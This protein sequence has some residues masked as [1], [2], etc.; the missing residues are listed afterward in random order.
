[1]SGDDMVKLYWRTV[2]ILLVGTVLVVLGLFFMKGIGGG[3]TESESRTTESLA[4]TESVTET[5]QTTVEPVKNENPLVQDAIFE[6]HKLMEWF[7][8]AKFD[9]DIEMLQQMVSPADSYNVDRLYEERYGKD[10]SGLLEIENY[11]VRSCYT[12]NGL[13]DGTYIVWVFVEVKYVNAAASAPALYRMYVCRKDDGYY[14][15]N[16]VLEEEAAYCEE[17]SAMEDVQE[18]VAEVNQRFQEVLDQ[19]EQLKNI[20]LVMKGKDLEEDSSSEEVQDS[21]E[22]QQAE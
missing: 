2:F 12:K 8:Q 17:V 16:E 22:I 18:L 10:E 5:I 21:E 13:T 4:P 1:M 14:I 3:E 20:V 11:H 15:N 9:C 6:I 7:F 19:D